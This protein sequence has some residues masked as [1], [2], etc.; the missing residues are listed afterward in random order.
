MVSY[1]YFI[2]DLI[3]KCLSTTSALTLCNNQILSVRVF[4]IPINKNYDSKYEIVTC[5]FNITSFVMSGRVGSGRVGSGRVGSGTR[6][7]P[8]W[9]VLFLLWCFFLPFGPLLQKCLRPVLLHSCK[10]DTSSRLA[11]ASD[12]LSALKVLSK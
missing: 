4:I 7:Q 1:K 10:P 8:W 5:Y 12:W 6:L 9:Q 3:N 11:N 2:I